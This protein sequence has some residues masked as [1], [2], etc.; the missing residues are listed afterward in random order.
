MATRTIWQDLYGFELDLGQSSLST[1]VATWPDFVTATD[2]GIQGLGSGAGKFALPLT[3]HPNFKSPSATVDTEEARG[4]SPRH[5]NEFNVAA[6]GEPIEFTIPMLGNAYNVGSMI[7]LLFQ[8]GAVESSP[9]GQTSMHAITGSPY[10]SA[11]CDN[12]AYFTR[13]LQPGTATEDVDLVVKGAICS[14]L[15]LSGEAGGLLTIEPTIQAA[16]WDQACLGSGTL[17]STVTITSGG[18]GYTSGNLVISGGGG[19]GMAGTFVAV[20]GVITEVTISSLGSGYT[21]LPTIDGDAGGNADATLTPSFTIPAGLTTNLSGSFADITPLKFQDS[22]IGIEY[23]TGNWADI[24]VPSI[25][26]TVGTNPMF[27]FYNDDAASSIHLGRL[28]VEGSLTFPWNPGDTNVD[29]NWIV[30]KFLNGVPFRLAWY[31]GKTSGA[32][33]VGTDADFAGGTILDR[34]KNDSAATNPKSFVSVIMNV[35]VTDYEI[36]GDNELQIE[37]TLQGVSDDTNEAVIIRAMYA[38]TLYNLSA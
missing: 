31:W 8:N 23:S 32:V 22:T 11:D 27:N 34:Y 13:S 35:K 17:S 36:S 18:T 4:M 5:N 29:K 2:I 10:T 12:Y 15:T 14:A 9:T 20:A 24:F 38:D 6:S 19:T 3:D 1:H 30:N 7:A 16:K 26:V 28:T 33:N 21:S 37:A 25:S